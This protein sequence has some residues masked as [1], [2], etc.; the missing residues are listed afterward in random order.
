MIVGQAGRK[1][2][3]G[4]DDGGWRLLGDYVGTF[5]DGMGENMVITVI[6]TAG[7]CILTN[8]DASLTNSPANFA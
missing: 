6:N 1:M 5:G 8:F 7:M 4:G 2:W 3:W